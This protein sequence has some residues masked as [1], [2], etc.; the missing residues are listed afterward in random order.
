MD[1]LAKLVKKRKLGKICRVGTWIIA[2]IGA[3]QLV[4]QSYTLW[5][6]YTQVLG[7]S[8]QGTQIY[9]P[10]FSIFT[11]YIPLMLVNTSLYV[12][13][14]IVLYCASVVFDAFSAQV[15]ENKT[16]EK[17]DENELDDD[18]IVYTSLKPEEVL[19]SKKSFGSK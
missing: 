19:Q 3:V 18:G 4:S 6:T 8:F 10:L 12:F 15:A 14:C 9:S 16:S 7:D 1:T 17:L 2:A 5:R 11:S 13:Y